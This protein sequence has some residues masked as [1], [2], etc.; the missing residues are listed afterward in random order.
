MTYLLKHLPESSGLQT[1]NYILYM[2]KTTGKKGIGK[3]GC[4][5]TDRKSRTERRLEAPAPRQLPICLKYDPKY[6]PAIY[7]PNII[8]EWYLKHC[9]ERH[10]DS[11]LFSAAI[12]CCRKTG[13]FSYETTLYPVFLILK[14]YLSVYTELSMIQVIYLGNSVT[15][16]S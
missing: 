4:N 16:Y 12:N 15:L 6:L 3:E 7:K 5:Q 11:P 8:E 1:R 2:L 13:A 14:K 10:L 9:L